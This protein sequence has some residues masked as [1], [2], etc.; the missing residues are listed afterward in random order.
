[1][2][3]TKRVGASTKNFLDVK[4]YE[5]ISKKIVITRESDE[6]L[7]SY[8][9][10]KNETSGLKKVTEDAIVDALIL[11]LMKDSLFREWL[12]A[13]DKEE[14]VSNEASCVS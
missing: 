5:P 11:T 13:K 1:M 6:T 9:K 3:R 14:R 12:G 8:T 4:V 10:F 7:K 2:G